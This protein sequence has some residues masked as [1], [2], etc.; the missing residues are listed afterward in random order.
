MTRTRPRIATEEDYWRMFDLIR[1][2]VETAI[3]SNFT[4]LTIHRLAA[5]NAEIF[6][7]YNRFAEFWMLNA[8]SLQTTFFVTFGRIFDTRRDVYSVHKVVEGAI[9]NPSFF[10][11]SALR[12]RK[13]KASRIADVDPGW[14]VEYVAHA[15]EPTRAE[16]EPLRIALAPNFAKF[17]AIYQ[18]IRHQVFAHKSI[19]PKRLRD[20]SSQI[21][22]PVH[23][24]LSPMERAGK[25]IQSRPAL[26]LPQGRVR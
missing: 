8:Y 19:Q 26:S 20:E 4:Y 22:R 24:R 18:P 15:W 9:A 5:E 23:G 2:D 13:R 25:E 6:D 14:L 12:A 11:K 16:L 10:S 21:N 7:K 17:K 1:G 3:K